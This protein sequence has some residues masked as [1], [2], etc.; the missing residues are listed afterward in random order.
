VNRSIEFRRHGYT[1]LTRL[2][3]EIYYRSSLSV[4]CSYEIDRFTKFPPKQSIQENYRSQRI[5]SI[6][7]LHLRMKRQKQNDMSNKK[8]IASIYLGSTSDENVYPPL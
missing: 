6:V 4:Q 1:P 3:K 8:C 2:N 5:Y 7:C